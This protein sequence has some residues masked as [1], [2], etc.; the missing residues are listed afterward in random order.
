MLEQ[1]RA[2][3]DANPWRPNAIALVNLGSHHFE[4]KEFPKALAFYLKALK[5]NPDYA[6][7]HRNLASIYARP[8]FFSRKRVVFHLRRTL[9]LDPDQEGADQLHDILEQ[10]EKEI[11]TQGEDKEKPKASS[12]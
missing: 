3:V 5:V 8:E 4:K 12:S 6:I 7:A 2:A 1:F 11:Q 10:A 9:E